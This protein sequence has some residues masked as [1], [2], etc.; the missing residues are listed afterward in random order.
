M[1]IRKTSR[2]IQL[3][4]LGVFLV[5]LA[6]A[7]YP[8]ILPVPPDLFLK[9]DP[10]IALGTFLSA[11]RLPLGLLVASLVL[12][13]ATLWLG[14]FF[15]GY[16][17]PLG[18]TLDLLDE[19]ITA[20]YRKKEKAGADSKG[21]RLRWKYYVL[22]GLLLSCLA[23]TTFLFIFDPV[24]LAT[25]FYTLVIYPVVV[26]AVNGILQLLRPLLV[27]SGS[28]LA[29]ARLGPAS[30]SMMLPTLLLLAGLVILQLWERRFWCRNLCP[31]GALLALVG[32]LRLLQ[33]V[34]T[35]DCTD[36]GICRQVCPAGALSGNGHGA[37]AG[38]C[39]VCRSCEEVCPEGAVEFTHSG[40]S[41][42]RVGGPVDVTRRGVV[43][44]GIMGIT[45][46]VMGKQA[47]AE[48]GRRRLIRPP[49]ALPEDRFLETCVRCGECMK[50]CLTNVLQPCFL[51][52]GWEGIW[53][54]RLNCRHA[55]CEERC[56]VCGHV[57]PTRAI[58]ALSLEEK[59]FARIGTA[60][61]DRSRCIAW[62]QNKECLI[63]DEACPYNAIDFRVVVNE[64]GTGK[65]PFVEEIKC[66]G[67][68][69]CE[70]N[71]PVGGESAIVI[72]A[73]GE[74]RL[75]TGS[76]ITEEVRRA[77][78]PE[79]DRE[80]DYFRPVQGSGECLVPAESESA[81]LP[82]GFMEGE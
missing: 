10:L 52:S 79:T 19:G 41:R 7:T 72:H 27:E 25:R 60:V 16:V 50:A 34:V 46:G 68:G 18:T 9:L 4:S 80:R 76:Y 75:E 42:A 44:A 5:L 78:E 38:E 43:T 54:P 48:P 32:R 71:C 55:G 29:Y 2:I 59:Q 63:C 14:R 28:S 53:T 64:C 6:S 65:R 21:R 37:M 61:I 58:R 62:E 23:G 15:C 33:R 51:E 13:A 81:D 24:S 40:W 3:I 47:L 20:R 67:C 12:V 1:K 45:L 57:C 66:T 73:D 30:F 35:E 82:P 70:Q 26:A 8:L 11:H 36:C 77:R 56:N 17:C 69:L 39:L 74:M 31:L 49:G 22:A